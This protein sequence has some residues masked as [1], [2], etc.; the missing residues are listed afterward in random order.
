ML[1]AL[2]LR[3]LILDELSEDNGLLSGL[4]KSDEKVFL[5]VLPESHQL[6]GG[7]RAN[8]HILTHENAGHHYVV[9]PLLI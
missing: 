4:K 8:A 7:T 2:N 3:V 1:H 6:E 9:L 5:V